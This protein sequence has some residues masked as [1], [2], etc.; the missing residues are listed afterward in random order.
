MS[1]RTVAFLCAVL[2]MTLRPPVATA[3]TP[4]MPFSCNDFRSDAE[5]HRYCQELERFSAFLA[6]KDQ[7]LREREGRLILRERG[8]VKRESRLQERENRLDES[9]TRCASAA[10]PP[11]RAE[12]SEVERSLET[13]RTELGSRRKDLDTARRTI[14]AL[15]A[16]LEAPRPVAPSPA[17]VDL[18]RRLDDCRVSNEQMRRQLH[19][20]ANGR[21]LPYRET[22]PSPETSPCDVLA[23]DDDIQ[24]VCQQALIRHSRGQNPTLGRPLIDQH[25]ICEIHIAG[26]WSNRLVIQKQLIGFRTFARRSAPVD[27]VYVDMHLAGDFCWS[28]P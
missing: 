15:R 21:T 2:T 18:R 20:Q 9:E 4:D 11:A 10:A 27:R 22:S 12:Y 24:R 3:Q 8:L 14:R 7:D 6:N 19:N 1:L 23:F 26:P 13:C 16:D 25:G 17:L 28:L 5:Q